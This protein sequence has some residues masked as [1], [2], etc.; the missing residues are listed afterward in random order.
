M[1]ESAVISEIN[2]SHG[3]AETHRVLTMVR[4]ERMGGFVPK[5]ESRA[6]AQSVV[7]ADLKNAQNPALLQENDQALGYA[8]YARAEEKTP[9]PQSEF[10]FTDLIDIINPLQHIPLV[11]QVYRELSGDEIKPSS[12]IVGG[13]LFAGPIGAAGGI[14]DAVI[15]NETGDDMTGNA[16]AMAFGREKHHKTQI[17][18]N[19]TLSPERQIEQA[20]ASLDQPYDNAM[21]LTLM[22]FGNLAA[23]ASTE[24]EQAS[25]HSDGLYDL[26]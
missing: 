20:L 2:Q 6:F 25:R 13:A 16:M 18:H 22:S 11:A 4:N 5:W 21:A 9:Q 23:P 10:G 26:A 14:I 24:V 12:K 19:G 3:P 17:A 8:V 15:V 1:I 7:E